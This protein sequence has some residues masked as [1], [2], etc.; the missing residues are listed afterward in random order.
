MY[1]ANDDVFH[2]QTLCMFV[3]RVVYE[4]IY[5]SIAADTDVNVSHWA[6]IPIAYWENLSRN[7]LTAEKSLNIVPH[8][9]LHLPKIFDYYVKNY[10]RQNSCLK[11]SRDS[12]SQ[13]NY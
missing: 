3:T 8:S 12:G 10:F 5:W 13:K 7:V 6:N 11:A 9:S 4:L 2:V 1:A